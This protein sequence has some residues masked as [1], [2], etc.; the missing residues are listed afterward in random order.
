M[1]NVEL[2]QQVMQHIKDHPEQHD[3]QIVVC[4]TAACFAGRAMLLSDWSSHRIACSSIPEC[5]QLLG[6]TTIQAQKLFRYDNTR[7]MLELMVKD[8]INGEELRPTYS[9][10]RQVDGEV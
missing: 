9:Y 3:Q 6:L 1:P 8:L 4:G 10:A 7:P 5:A 2:L